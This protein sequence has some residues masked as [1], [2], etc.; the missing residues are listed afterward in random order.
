MFPYLTILSLVLMS[1][2]FDK[3]KVEKP[4][5]YLLCITLL[6]FSAFRVGGTGPED[7]DVYLRLYS[8]VKSWIDVIDPNIHAEIGFRLLSYFGNIFNL[9]PQF[10]IIAMAFLAF[11]SVFLVVS[12]QSYYPILSLLIWLPYFLTMNMHSSRVSVSAG[13]GLLCINA[14]MHSNKLRT[15]IFFFTAVSFHSSAL[16]LL[17]LPLTKLSYRTLIGM[18]LIAI[19][20]GNLLNIFPAIESVFSFLGYSRIA[21]AIEAYQTSSD[22]GYAMSL[23]DPRIL[24]CLL[25][26]LLIYNI[27]HSVNLNIDHYYFKTY[28]IGTIILIAFSSITILSWRLSYFYLITS[29]LVIPK[30]SYYYNI[31]LFESLSHVRLMTLFMSIVYAAYTILFIS[32]AEPYSFYFF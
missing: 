9:D 1:A 6:F 18:L 27:R 25:I 15:A 22:Y 3:S 10:I 30:I 13:F 14:Y 17:I 2:I 20:L 26:C 21:W 8:H 4:I 32:I 5:Y 12:K 28:Y 16:I 29:V 24:L 31:R 7:Y 11:G 23:Y 19:V